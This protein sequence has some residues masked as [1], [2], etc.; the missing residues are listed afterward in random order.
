MG[1]AWSEQIWY[2]IS[3]LG[4]LPVLHN[5]N[6]VGEI[7]SH[8]LLLTNT[9]YY[10]SK[11]SYDHLKYYRTRDNNDIYFKNKQLLLLQRL[12]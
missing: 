5:I 9:F 3:H 11:E 2:D 12:C 10:Y 1:G 8:N 6:N 4:L 7:E